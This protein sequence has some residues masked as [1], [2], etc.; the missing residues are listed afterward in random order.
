MNDVQHLAAML[1]EY[2]EKGCNDFNAD[3]AKHFSCKEE[4]E[5]ILK[6]HSKLLEESFLD[7]IKKFSKDKKFLSAIE[8]SPVYSLRCTPVPS[9]EEVVK[10]GQMRLAIQPT[11][12]V[13][14]TLVKMGYDLPTKATI[15]VINKLNECS[16]RVLGEGYGGKFHFEG[17]MEGI[18]LSGKIATTPCQKGLLYHFDLEGTDMYNAV[19]E[20]PETRKPR[21]LLAMKE[22]GMLEKRS[23]QPKDKPWIH[24]R[25]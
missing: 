16:D 15:D 7:K 10:S 9:L 14:E 19:Y 5:E 22:M 25:K 4:V 17:M 23:F 3:L 1:A 13:Q 24:K 11:D 12:S 6:Q 20:V 18:R 21:D 8:H 2:Q